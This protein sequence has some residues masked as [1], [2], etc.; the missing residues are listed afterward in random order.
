M[1]QTAISEAIIIKLIA[2][3]LVIMMT[4]WGLKFILKNAPLKKSF[5]SGVARVMPMIEGIAWL[6]FILWCVRQLVH[7]QLWNSIGVLIVV[8]LVLVLIF[9]FVVRD[10]IAGIIM[11]SDG[12]IKANDWI[13]IKG[14]EG[15]V[16]EMGQ[17][18]LIITTT[19]GETV[20]VPYSAVAGEISIKPNPSEKLISHTFELKTNK[21]TDLESTIDQIH[22]IIL[23]A[24]WSSVK[25]APEIKMLS[26]TAGTY[27][28][29]I[30][31]YSIRLLY[32]QK[33][34]DYLKTNLAD[35]II[36]D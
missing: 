36:K 8:L 1:E 20:N 26:D 21:T 22:R 12:S 11:K 33:I 31:I 28:F 16:T 7:H 4:L 10:F 24:P 19:Q 18:A 25:R 17:R 3:A 2:V 34:K 30:S 29:E 23:S 9:W 15:K 32:F 14:I 27:H 35:R 6:A 13:R 5:K